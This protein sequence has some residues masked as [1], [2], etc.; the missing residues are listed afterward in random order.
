MIITI[1]C[2]EQVPNTERFI[3]R[4]TAFRVEQITAGG[5][6]FV[7][8]EAMRLRDA[9]REEVKEATE[10]VTFRDKSGKILVRR[11]SI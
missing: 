4:Q 8:G 10:P 1:I 11:R 9:V 3:S 5:P 7:Y 2:D 6:P